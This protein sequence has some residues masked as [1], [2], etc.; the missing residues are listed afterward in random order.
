MNKNNNVQI[1]ITQNIIQ[2][3]NYGSN[4]V[5][6]NSFG[7][8]GSGGAFNS[9]SSYNPGSSLNLKSDDDFSNLEKAVKKASTNDKKFD[10]LKVGLIESYI[11]AKQ[12]N[13]LL[14]QFITSH[15]SKVA[16]L[17]YSHI[18]DLNNVSLAFESISTPSG[19]DDAI[20]ALGLD[21]P[22][23]TSTNGYVSKSDGEAADVE[24]RI[25]SASTN[26]RKVYEI[27]LGLVN[28]FVTCKQAASWLKQLNFSH[29]KSAT[30]MIYPHIS[31][32]SN[33]T[34]L[35]AA[36]TSPSTKT[37]TMKALGLI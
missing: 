3:N 24:K 34:T 17:L 20:K 8:F 35:F 23:V 19:K 30:L 22:T 11:T 26:D 14:K 13:A 2:N 33:L 6:I 1:N 32:R 4:N 15:Q 31:D 29:Q 37:E 25:K 27:S 5:N 7:D 12:A 16:I 28:S 21:N 18:A 10:E 9:T 36:H